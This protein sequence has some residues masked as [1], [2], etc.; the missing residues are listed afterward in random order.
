MGVGADVLVGLYLSSPETDA[1]MKQASWL[2][3]TKVKGENLKSN[4]LSHLASFAPDD[5][6]KGHT[7]SRLSKG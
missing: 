4:H 6:Q 5:D 3:E 1:T 7:V 2:E